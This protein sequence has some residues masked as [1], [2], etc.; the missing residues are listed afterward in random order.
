MLF[1]EASIFTEAA[2]LVLVQVLLQ[3]DDVRLDPISTLYYVAPSCFVI[4][5]VPFV[6][7]EVP[8]MMA[9][10]TLIIPLFLL[11]LSSLTAFGRDAQAQ[12]AATRAFHFLRTSHQARCIHTITS[13]LQ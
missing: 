11:I 5:T 8:L 1:Q 2:R 9:E 4:L 12:P 13:V 10:D 6:F 3:Q 7:M